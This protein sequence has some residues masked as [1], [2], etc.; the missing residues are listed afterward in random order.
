MTDRESDQ[1]RMR[2]VQS[3]LRRRTTPFP[4]PAQDSGF[5]PLRAS[6]TERSS[7]GLPTLDDQPPSSVSLEFRRAFL[8]PPPGGRLRFDAAF[9]GLPFGPSTSQPT[10]AVTFPWPAQKSLNWS[11]G[12]VAPRD[13]RSVVT[14]MG[15]WTV[16]SVLRPMGG[17]Q[18]EYHSSTWIGLDGMRMYRDSSLPQ[19]GTKQ[20]CNAAGGVTYGAWYQWWARELQE[21]PECLE[22]QVN[23][24][25]E[26]AAVMRVL[27]DKQTVRFNLKNVTLG[28]MLQ[29][30]DVTAPTGYLVSG[31]TAEWIMERPSPPRSDGW[32][33]YK[34]PSYS[35]FSFTDCLAEAS[36]SGDA[37]VI[38][39][40]LELARLIRMYEIVQSPRSIRTI[41]SAKKV[42]TSPQRLELTY[43][44][45]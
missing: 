36:A 25:D 8:S 38:P 28:I 41:S 29:A 3:E 32:N 5:D 37:V 17:G 9:T 10:P 30:F 35:A 14:V 33:A 22:L 2:V 18:P 43:L 45:N 39:I 11:G 27:D 40:D 34:L 20:I 13:G 21:G 16:P 42:L 19:I 26:I 1:R 23:P 15:T 4:I 7:F 31:A 24:G 6:D 44:G 12:Y